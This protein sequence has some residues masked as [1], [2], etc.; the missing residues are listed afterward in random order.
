[1]RSWTWIVA[2]IL[3]LSVPA[4]GAHAWQA[5]ECVQTQLN[6]LGYDAGSVDGSIGPATRAALERYERIA[7]PL[8]ALRL[9]RHTAIVHCRQL[10]LRH[11]TA[12]LA[13]PSAETPFTI[14]SGE[15]VSP[16]FQTGIT[17]GIRLALVQLDKEFGITLAAPFTVYLGRDRASILRLAKASPPSPS[18]IDR[19]RFNLD[20]N[21]Q[22]EGVDGFSIP[23]AIVICGAPGPGPL[24][25]SMSTFA[26]RI[27]RHELFHELQFQFTGDR[28]RL[29][30]AA[31]LAAYGPKWL[32]EGS[33]DLFA[34]GLL[35]ADQLGIEGT[36]REARGKRLKTLEE[37]GAGVKAGQVVYTMGQAGASDLARRSGGQKAIF[38]FYAALGSGASWPDAFQTAFGL[39]PEAFYAG[40]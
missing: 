21:C 4:T 7:G 17:Q 3:A 26:L 28:P 6:A 25:V 1:M 13:W 19:L 14:L 10:G 35:R 27:A 40:R 34:Y 11:R 33:A 16:A 18:P 24:D 30:E 39:T 9:D 38:A 22:G 32:T 12:R 29:G 20:G 15:D 23:G 5:A 8:T 2:A 36:A 31:W 37:H